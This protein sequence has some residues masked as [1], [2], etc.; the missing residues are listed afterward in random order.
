[1][2]RLAPAGCQK[3]SGNGATHPQWEVAAET[4]EAGGMPPTPGYKPKRSRD[5]GRDFAVAA[6]ICAAFATAPTHA[7]VM[8]NFNYIDA[9]VGFNDPTTGAARRGALESA[10]NYVSS[11]L[12]SYTA[13]LDIEVNGA[14]TS[15]STLASAS[16]EFN[17]PFPGNGFAVQGD[18]M[19]KILG[20][21]RILCGTKDGMSTGISP[22][23][24]GSSATTSRPV[25]STSSRPQSMNFCMPS[26]LH[27]KSR[28]PASTVLT[29]RRALPGHGRRST[30]S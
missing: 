14:V 15:A 20:N 24:P 8:W 22:T 2:P 6:A 18:V 30:S 16:S 9:G 4:A 1:M 5:T 27:R 17:A 13:T 10:A 29:T 19:L 21:G 3:H 26:D 11:F 23:S 28:K 7:A 25:S 12:T